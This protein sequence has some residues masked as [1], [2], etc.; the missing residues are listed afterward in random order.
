MSK[1]IL[2]GLGTILAVVA[3]VAGMAAY[4]AHVINVTAKIEN[5]LRVHPQ[6]S[7]NFGTVFPQEYRTRS[8]TI[9]TSD[10]FCAE[11]QT[12]VTSIDY[13]IVQKPKPVPAYEEQVGEDD[14]RKWCHDNYPTEPYPGQTTQGELEWDDYMVNCYYPLCAYLSKTPVLAETGDIGV[15]AFHDPWFE[16][17]YGTIDKYADDSD[18]WIIDL[19]V[20]CFENQCAQD[21]T[22]QGWELPADLESEIFGCDLWVEVT[23]IY[24][25]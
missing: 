7:M 3:G 15:P 9:G 17:A 19:D 18:Q 25:P 23:G 2:L 13:K 5:A 10:S 14:A 20:P 21:W 22:H 16:V 4:E 12:R 1:K 11:G 8:L 24:L 6:E